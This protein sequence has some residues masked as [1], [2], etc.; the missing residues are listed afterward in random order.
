M[1]AKSIPLHAM[2]VLL[3][4]LL[5]IVA[6]PA[7]AADPR[8]V[9]VPAQ[10]PPPA[11]PAPTPK[12]SQPATPGM[13]EPSLVPP[14]PNPGAEQRGTEQ[15]PWVV[16]VLPTPN[17]AEELEADRREREE[18]A[19]NE[20]GL[21]TYT[22]DLWIATIGLVLVAAV[23][24]GLFVWQLKLLRRSIGDSAIAAKAARDAANAATATAAA[25]ET[26]ADTANRQLLLT[27]Q[28]RLRV[29]NI[30]FQRPAGAQTADLFQPGEPIYGQL[31]VRNIGGSQ[32]TVGESHCIVYWRKGGLPMERP[33]EG[34]RA[35]NFM[36]NPTLQP[37]EHAR[38]DFTT[39]LPG[40]TARVMG[41]EG[42]AVFRRN[43]NWRIWVMGWIEFVDDLKI[44][45]RV[46]FCREWMTDAMGEGRLKPVDDRDYDRDQ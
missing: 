17:T 10:T 8:V 46:V 37:G 15:S 5:I 25:T 34:Y 38:G 45:R 28:P 41:D 14:E 2:P 11:A 32:A 7:F 13:G 26:N 21:T 12:P 22:R 33:Y 27:Q 1:F 30:A 29:S 40:C 44:P 39:Y 31:F 16:R 9:T 19:A 23:Q 42:P 43:D 35:N 20:G 24:A 6:R 4:V 36:V 18:R 3:L